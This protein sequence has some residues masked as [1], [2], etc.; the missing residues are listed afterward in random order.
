MRETAA[1]IGR[2]GNTGDDCAGCRRCPEFAAA[3]GYPCIVKPAAVRR[4]SESPSCADDRDVDWPSPG[5][6]HRTTYV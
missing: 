6:S 4:A 1:R 2:G 3:H 5:R